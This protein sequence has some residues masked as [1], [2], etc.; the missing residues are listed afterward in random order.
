M[1][2]LPHQC[3][4]GCGTLLQTRNGLR[5]MVCL[6]IWQALPHDLRVAYTS[7]RGLRFKTVAA[8]RILNHVAQAKDAREKKEAA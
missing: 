2:D 1:S 5:Y 4:C 8:R 3:P 6:P 7:A